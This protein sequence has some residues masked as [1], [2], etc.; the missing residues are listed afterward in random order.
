MEPGELRFSPASL[1]AYLESVRLEIC[2]RLVAILLDD[3]LALAGSRALLFACRWFQ[4]TALC[5][6]G[7]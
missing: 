2:Q 1:P 7:Q 4:L 3:D 6:D 5:T